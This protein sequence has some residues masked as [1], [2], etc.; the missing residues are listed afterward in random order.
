[1][2][3]SGDQPYQPNVLNQIQQK[4]DLLSLQLKIQR[5]WLAF[6]IYLETFIVPFS[7]SDNYQAARVAW[8][9]LLEISLF[10]VVWAA[11]RTTEWK[12]GLFFLPFLFLYSLLWF[13]SARSLLS[14]NISVIV[15]LLVILSFWAL[16]SGL[17][18]LCGILLALATIQ[19][20][21]VAL[22]IGFTLIWAI[23]SK[24]WRVLVWLLGGLLILFGISSMFVPNWI[25]QYIRQLVQAYPSSEIL[26]PQSVFLVRF[27]GIGSRMGWALTTVVGIVLLI[28]WWLARGKEFRWYFWTACLTL[29]LTPW[30]GIPLH[31]ETLVIL[32][33]PLI[34]ICAILE[35]AWGSHIRLLIILLMFLLLVSYWIPYFSDL[36]QV[37]TTNRPVYMFTLP[38]LVFAGLYWVRWRST[39]PRKL[40]ISELKAREI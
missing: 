21:V 32:L 26:T 19:P 22:L 31:Q 24:R 6:P 38:A 35:E 12:V 37:F 30:I 16:K 25:I 13:F 14:G 27:P 3:K 5:E 7:L 11:A 39:R 28:E 15:A 10:L 33:I 34:L 2:L 40:L 18:E 23:S 8:M 29:A 1:L 20:G 4:A 36:S 17:D 9:I